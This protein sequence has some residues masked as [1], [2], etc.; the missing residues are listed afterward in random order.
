MKTRDYVLVN[1][2]NIS[3]SQTFT[4]DLKTGMKIQE[5]RVIYQAT[6]GS[7]S[8]TL[9]KL[10]GMVSKLEVVDG[11]DVL[12]SLSFRQE[13][14]RDYFLT[15]RLPCQQ[16]NSKLGGVVIEE[17]DIYFGR[18]PGDRDFYLD[19]SRFK[20][21][22]LSLASALTISAT[23]GFET[24]KG[25]LTVILKLIEDA[26]PPCQGFILSKEAENF[27]TVGSGTKS[28]DL[29]TDFDYQ[30][31]MFGALET[32]IEPDVDISNYKLTLD[33]DRFIPFNLSATQI[34]EDNVRRLPAVRQRKNFLNDT[35]VNWLSDV[36][37]R[38]SGWMGPIGGTA[39]GGVSTVTAEQLVAYM[40]T[41][42]TA[43]LFLNVRGY[44]P[45]SFLEWPFGDGREVDDYL[46]VAGLS[47]AELIGTDAAAGGAYTVVTNQVRS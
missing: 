4:K 38:V 8:N 36:Y 15:G 14:A 19:T 37:G 17:A 6:N 24:A 20:N 35:A 45:H 31:L 32:T 2:Q 26:A 40:T 44:C 34:L 42:D 28:T 39:K 25:Y 10:N 11:S 1:A 5:L 7:T 22:M 29:A 3:D 27:T 9:G 21:A 12:H 18:F 13:Q 46:K 16:L 43:S 23:A 41:G 47:K 33:D 30:S